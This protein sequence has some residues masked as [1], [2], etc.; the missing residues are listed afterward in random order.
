MGRRNSVYDDRPWLKS[1]GNIPKE[2]PP[3]RH[4]NL[5]EMVREC[6]ERF[7]DQKAFTTCMPNGM[8]GTRT[9]T[10]IDAMS[11]DF[12]VYLREVVGLEPGD[13]VAIQLPNCLSYPVAAFGVFKAGCVLVN[14]NPLYTADEMEK[15]FA[16]SGAKALLI[17]DMFVDKLTQVLP[18]TQIHHVMVTSVAQ[19]FPQPVRGVLKGVLKY[20][21]RVIP[22]REVEAVAFGSALAQGRRV[23]SQEE[24]DVAAYT[25]GVGPQDVAVLQYTGG[26]TGVAK[27]AM[28]THLNLLANVDQVEAM[29]RSHIEEGAECVLTA[30][31]LYHI[32]AFTANL[33]SF[34]KVG[35]HNILVPSPRP[36]QNLQRALENY[37]V[38]WITG[39]NTLFNALLNEEWFKVYPPKHL[40]AAIAGGTALHAAVATRWQ[41]FTQTPLVEGYGLTESSPLLT[42]NP[43]DGK[44]KPGSI[45]FPV[46]ETDIRLVDEEGYVVPMGEAGELCAKGPQI[47]LGY[48]NRPDETEKTLRD[49]WLHTGDIAV[50]DEDG[51]FQIVD[52]KKDMINVSGFNVYPNEVEDCIA[53]MDAV[54][55]VGVIGIPD[56]KSGEAVCAVIV[57]RDDLNEQ[58]VRSFCREHLAAYKVP[59][60][61]EFREELPKTPI[62]K[63]L[64]KDLRADHQGAPPPPPEQEEEHEE[65]RIRARLPAKGPTTGRQR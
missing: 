19:F 55:E 5:A 37:P 58:E 53:R 8:Y 18:K 34:Y 22:K 45:G 39:V 65:P 63:V 50:M 46:P 6:S 61:V 62:G 42:F 52:R 51:Y 48:W 56:E 47:M 38:T 54:H 29:G 3:P 20:W 23:R 44:I 11:D 21:N 25:A 10:Q 14:V 30:L 49:G 17:I 57:K 33:L 12:A 32:F 31:P 16:D 26:T 1:Y 43:L 28:L 60:K 40:R 7:S 36:I 4:R 13:R 35:G 64:R 41:E 27:G 59:R 15:Q 9:F 24:V 2:L